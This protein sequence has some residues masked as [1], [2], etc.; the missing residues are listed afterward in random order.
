MIK[1]AKFIIAFIISVNIVATFVIAYV[2]LTK[3]VELTDTLNDT[4]DEIS[5]LKDDIEEMQDLQSKLMI[6]INDL[7]SNSKTNENISEEL[8]FYEIWLDKNNTIHRNSPNGNVRNLGWHIEYNG[9]T[10]L[11]R[12]AVG[13]TEYNY[14]L[15]GQSGTYVVYL[16]CWYDGAYRICSNSLTYTY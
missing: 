1:K 10:V 7:N 8:V 4:E 6:K 2:M 3:N 11:E 13:E 16:T 14:Y 15:N 12:N 9:E 5:D